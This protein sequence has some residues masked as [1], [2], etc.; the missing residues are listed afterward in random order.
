MGEGRGGGAGGGG[1]HIRQGG[2]YFRGGTVQDNKGKTNTQ[3]RLP[4]TYL[5][6]R[7]PSSN[8]RLPGEP[9]VPLHPP[10]PHPL[11]VRPLPAVWVPPWPQ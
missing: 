6:P 7:P 9:P 5:Y 11:P 2:T 4:V 10:P 8:L 1:D 3:Y